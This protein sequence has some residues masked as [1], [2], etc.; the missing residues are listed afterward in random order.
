MSAGDASAADG[1]GARPRRRS[2]R[3]H[4][5]PWPAGAARDGNVAANLRCPSL[6]IRTAS[7]TRTGL[8]GW[9]D[10]SVSK[11]RGRLSGPCYL[12]DRV[13]VCDMRTSACLCH[14]V[15]QIA[16]W[17][18]RSSP[19]QFGTKTK[20]NYVITWSGSPNFHRIF[21]YSPQKPIC[22]CTR[23]YVYYIP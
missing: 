22:Y 3:Q 16:A 11:W 14:R 10:G 21:M 15:R 5:W 17:I 6:Y 8:D 20:F 7:E 19:G 1:A 18:K 9:M 4:G 2:P 23:I 13:C 12:W